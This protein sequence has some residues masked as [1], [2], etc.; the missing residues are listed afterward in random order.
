MKGLYIRSNRSEGDSDCTLFKNLDKYHA[1]CVSE[2]VG[3]E[4]QDFYI[5]GAYTQSHLAAPMLFDSLCQIRESNEF[6]EKTS[7]FLMDANAHST[8]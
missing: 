2:I 4:Y 7:I 6:A 5:F 3:V 1:P 8:C